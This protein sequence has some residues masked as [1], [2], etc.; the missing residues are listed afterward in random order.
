MMSSRKI[1]TDIEVV[2]FRLAITDLIISWTEKGYSMDQ[3]EKFMH[4]TVE[5]GAGLWE[6]QLGLGDQSK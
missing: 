6:F 5:D 1:E 3:I 4:E 2:R